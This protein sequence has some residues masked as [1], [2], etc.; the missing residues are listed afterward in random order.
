MLD[1][2][3]LPSDGIKFEQL[4][5]EILLTEGFEIHWTGAGADG[6]R[7]LVLTEKLSGPLSENKRKWLVSCK[8][9]AHS[10]KSV[11]PTDLGDFSADCSAIDA[12]GYLLV[13]STQ[14]TSAAV[15]RLEEVKSAKNIETLF[16]DAIEIE[17]RL[18]S[19]NSFGLI[20][21]FFPISSELYKWNIYNAHSPSFW[22]A[23]YKKFFLYMSSRDATTF[24]S[25][26]AIEVII[27]V[28]EDIQFS[29]TELT[30]KLAIRSVYYDNKHCT[31]L[32]AIDYLYDK[33][34][35]KK[36]V[37]SSSDINTLLFE[38]WSE[39]EIDYMNMP[40]WDILA[41]EVSFGNDHYHLNHKNYYE[42][43][44]SYF[45]SGFPRIDF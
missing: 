42:P 36:G 39:L 30:Q 29:R 21:I 25:L 41:V 40:D 38:R 17:K 33:Y 28:M 43:F 16:W 22:A 13:C 35:D 34:G 18:M 45:K 31:Y 44:L 10:G 2:K 14:P 3:E 19:P 11:N 37:K 20:N 1:F 24:P 26:K 7:D 27:S 12:S 5:R 15:K 8:H 32:V 23:N 9:N 4:V 6:G